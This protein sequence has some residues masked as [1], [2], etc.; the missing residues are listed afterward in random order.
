VH[1]YDADGGTYLTV[2]PS[3]GWK[4]GD[5]GGTVYA[6]SDQPG[7]CRATNAVV[8]RARFALIEGLE[9]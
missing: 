8:A 9:R 3:G 4:L 5:D 2:D 7:V 6:T 1:L